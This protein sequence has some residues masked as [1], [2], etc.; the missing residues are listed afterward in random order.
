MSPRH[1]LANTKLPP[2]VD[3]E[4]AP[5]NS[6]VYNVTLVDCFRK[7][8]RHSRWVQRPGIILVLLLIV[9]AFLVAVV[10]SKNAT[11]HI[12]TPTKSIP[13]AHNIFS[14]YTQWWCTG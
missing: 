12:T 13:N 10:R 9:L 6:F 7:I 3:S 5:T 4:T 1:T 8:V 14:I 11:S 2:K